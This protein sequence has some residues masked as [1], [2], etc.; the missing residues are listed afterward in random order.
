MSDMDI[1]DLMLL[2][3]MRKEN[4]EEYKEF[5]EGIKHVTRD[6]SEIMRELM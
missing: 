2:I 3:K 1:K 6:L 5:L 4:P